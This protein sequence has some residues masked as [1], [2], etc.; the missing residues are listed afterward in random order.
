VAGEWG[1]PAA[2]RP[3]PPAKA[4][5]KITD[6]VDMMVS[7][8][9]CDIRFGL[10]QPLKSTDDRYNVML[11][12]IMKPYMYVNTVVPPYPRVILPKTYR[13]YV[14]PWIIP[15]AIYNVIFV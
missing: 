1:E 7:K 9:L 6:F 3:P 14:K 10:Y 15:N 8:V 13:G 12:N 5:L 4:K 2:T 11:K